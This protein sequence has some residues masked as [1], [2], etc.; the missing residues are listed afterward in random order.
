MATKPV[1]KDYSGIVT[2][3]QALQKPEIPSHLNPNRTKTKPNKRKNENLCS[4]KPHKTNKT[5]L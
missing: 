5:N 4:V 1:F 2:E 3:P